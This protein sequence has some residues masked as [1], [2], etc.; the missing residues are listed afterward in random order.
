MS[1]TGRSRVAS[2]RLAVVGVAVLTIVAWFL[3]QSGPALVKFETFSPE[4]LAT[5]REPYIVDIFALW[6]GPCLE[7]DRAVFSDPGVAR[8]SRGIRYFRIDH[9]V[10]PPAPVAQWLAPRELKGFPTVYFFDAQ[11][12][13]VVELRLLGGES[14]E[15]FIERL[16]KFRAR[17]G[18][19]A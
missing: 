3:L 7:M 8:A 19:D 15:L 9:T 18:L 17:V 12:R 13:E 1:E 6:C 5:V 11:G 14:P 2:I 16:R 4:V 10:A